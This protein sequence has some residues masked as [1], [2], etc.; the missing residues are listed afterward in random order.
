MKGGTMRAVSSMLPK[1]LIGAAIVTSTLVIPASVSAAPNNPYPCPSRPLLRKGSTGTCVKHVQYKLK[2]KTTGHFDNAT[3]QAVKRFE[4]RKGIIVDGIVGP[5]TWGALSAAS[6]N[7]YPCP[8]R[9][10]LR[11]GSTGTC[12]KH[13]QYKLKLKTTGHFDNATYQAVKRFEAQKEV[14]VNGIVGPQT[15]GALGGDKTNGGK[16]GGDRTGGGGNGGQCNYRLG[17]VKPHVRAAA[18][19]IGT[20]F[21]VKTIG[22]YAN[23]NVNKPGSTTK[24]PH[25]YGLGLDF[26]VGTNKAKGD[27]IANYSLKHA[28]RLKVE[29]VIWY[30]R[31]KYPG[32][33]WKRMSDR[34]SRTANHYDHP[35]ITF[36]R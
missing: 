7:P 12:V 14:P 28:K 8:S 36:Y 13:V 6:N 15:W 9:P 19:E 31:I 24:S 20:K 30:Q 26:M 29:Y 16:T 5:Q 22:G 23:R 32:G 27:A 2:L 3:Y 10:L 21:D 35:H 25:A 33:E 4:A 1:I 18:C 34:G 11:K 17:P